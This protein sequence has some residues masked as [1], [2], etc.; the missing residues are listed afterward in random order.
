VTDRWVS[1]EELDDIIRAHHVVFAP[2]MHAFNTGAPYVVLP[3]GVPV[4]LSPSRQAEWMIES[5][6]DEFVRLLPEFDD[7]DAIAA[8]LEWALAPR[9]ATSPGPWDWATAAEEH[10]AVYERALAG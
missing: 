3:A 5:Q 6:G 10:R 2:Q 1:D 8:L 9:P 4:V 7:R